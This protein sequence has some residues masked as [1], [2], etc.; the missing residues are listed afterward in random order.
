MSQDESSQA[1][2]ESLRHDRSRI[3]AGVCQRLSP[4]VRRLIAPNASP[5]TFTGTCSYIVGEGELSVIDPGPESPEHLAALLAATQGERIAHVFVTHTHRDH[6]PGARALQAATGA[7]IR[8]CAAHR[9]ILNH[10]SGR[11]DTSHDLAYAPNEPMADG[12]VFEGEGYTLEAVHTPGHASN[13]LCFAL[14]EENALFSGDHVMAWSTTIVAPPDGSMRDYV[15]GLERLR[16]RPEALYWPGHGAPVTEPQRYLRALIAHRSKRETIILARLETGAATI[17]QI[18][19]EAYPHIDERLKRAA[20]LS[21]FAH[22]DELVAR[23]LARSDEGAATLT[24][25]Y[26]RA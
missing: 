4:R 12:D 6:S 9:E 24:A 2:T 26:R 20:G 22:L 10:P 18:V 8:G 5:F 25:T 11:A 7:T 17:E 15:A 16:A 23:G 19:E 14:K 21:T 1:R 13:H 3:E